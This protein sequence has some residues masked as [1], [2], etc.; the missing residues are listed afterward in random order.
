M[1]HSGGQHREITCQCGKSFTGHPMRLD[2]QVR[3]HNKVCSA[4]KSARSK[5]KVKVIV[6][7]KIEWTADATHSKNIVVS[8]RGN[9]KVNTDAHKLK[10]YK[11]GKFD[12]DYNVMYTDIVNKK[13]AERDTLK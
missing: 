12:Y 11:G 9:F 6:P 10:V 5:G 3:L 4:I 13:I 2:T 8:K 1:P 7:S